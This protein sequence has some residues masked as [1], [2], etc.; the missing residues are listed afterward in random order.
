MRLIDVLTDPGDGWASAE[1]AN[2]ACEFWWRGVV[3]VVYSS[4][5]G[6]A[7]QWHTPTSATPDEWLAMNAA[8]NALMAKL[9]RVNDRQS[10]GEVA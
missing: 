2:G 7:W 8:A 5:K 1:R 4:H 9:A 10:Q 3:R 6:T